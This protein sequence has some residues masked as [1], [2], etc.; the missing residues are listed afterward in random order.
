VG[1]GELRVGLGG[2]LRWIY[3]FWGISFSFGDDP[4]LFKAL[5]DVFWCLHWVS[6]G[7][8]WSSC[9]KIV[10]CGFWRTSG[11]LRGTLGMDLWL[12]G[13]SF[14]FGFDPVLA[15][16]VFDVFWVLRWVLLSSRW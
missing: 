7:F 9:W 11:R 6:L 2:L 3:G 5:F 4:V 1:F 12:L 14:V 15:W 16:G 10:N 8:P 13:F